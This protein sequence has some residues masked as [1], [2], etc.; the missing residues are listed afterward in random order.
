MEMYDNIIVIEKD[1][2]IWLIEH[3]TDK[4]EL[5]IVGRPQNNNHLMHQWTCNHTERIGIVKDDA[6]NIFKL[7]NDYSKGNLDLHIYQIDFPTYENGTRDIIITFRQER[8]KIITIDTR[9]NPYFN[10]EN[11]DKLLENHIVTTKNLLS[12]IDTLEN[13]VEKLNGTVVDLLAVIKS[14]SEF[15][16]DSDKLKID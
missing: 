14:Y 2:V 5:L 6:T 16:D 8:N 1:N 13:T 3:H 11:R 4:H 7:F 9:Q 10:K 15:A 12:R